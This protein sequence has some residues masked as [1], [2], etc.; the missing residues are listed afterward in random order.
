MG[1]F[2][3][4]LFFQRIFWIDLCS[5][6]LQS[7]A[8]LINAVPP[9][10]LSPVCSR[11]PRTKFQTEPNRKTNKFSMTTIILQYTLELSFTS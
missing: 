2:V 11:S 6:V 5:K 9:I 3:T 4:A 10:D 1:Y 8:Y 7:L